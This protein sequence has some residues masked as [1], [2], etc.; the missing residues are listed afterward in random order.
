[1]LNAKLIGYFNY[2]GVHGNLQSLEFF[3][4]Q[5]IRQMWKYLNR[6]SQRK[7]Y[8][9]D[10]FKQLLAQFGVVKPHFANK[11]YQ[12]DTMNIGN[13]TFRVINL[14]ALILFQVTVGLLGFV[15]SGKMNNSAWLFNMLFLWIGVTIGMYLGGIPFFFQKSF[16]FNNPFVRLGTTALGAFIPVV[17]SV[18]LGLKLGINNP[19]YSAVAPIFAVS[20]LVL[21]LLGFYVP[22]WLLH[23][24]QSAA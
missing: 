6:R 16:N 10:G 1:L 17:F 24:K 13:K 3:L 11:P 12:G 21:S 9:W 4:Y 5:I 7:S 14:I 20:A 2:F 8:N 15:I 22:T 18:L 19:V 23:Q